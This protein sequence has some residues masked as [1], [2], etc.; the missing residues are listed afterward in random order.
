M[1]ALVGIVGRKYAGKDTLAKMAFPSAVNVK[2]ADPL[3]NMVRTLL[4]HAGLSDADIERCVEGDLKEVAVVGPAGNPHITPRHIMQTLG[5]EWRQMIYQDLWID[6]FEK[7]VVLQMCAGN[8]VVCTDVRFGFEAERIRALGGKLIR[9][10]RPQTE[11]DDPHPSE[12]EI[13]FIPVDVE[14]L[15]DGDLNDLQRKID[16][17]L[18]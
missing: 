3:K 16:A 7:T 9:V 13:P 15:N 4:R 18:R 6:M 17:H 1:S 14:I 11:V 12:A 8:T 10:R 2:M 5:T